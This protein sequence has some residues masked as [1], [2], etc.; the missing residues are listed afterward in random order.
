MYT[1]SCIS[2]TKRAGPRI[3]FTTNY[4]ILTGAMEGY[5]K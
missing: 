1:N 3:Q 5:K 4:K 2:H